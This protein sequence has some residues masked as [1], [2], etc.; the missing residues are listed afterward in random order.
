M[1]S[2][3]ISSGNLSNLSNTEIY[4][5]LFDSNSNPNDENSKLTKVQESKEL[6]PLTDIGIEMQEK[7][8]HEEFVFI[9]KNNRLTPLH[10]SCKLLRSP[11]AQSRITSSKIMS[12]IKALKESHKKEDDVKQPIIMRSINTY[13]LGDERSILNY[14]N[15]ENRLKIQRNIKGMVRN[16]TFETLE[17]TRKTEL[18]KRINS[19][20]PIDFKA[21]FKKKKYHDAKVKKW[22]VYESLE[23]IAGYSRDIYARGFGETSNMS[24]ISL[25]WDGNYNGSSWVPTESSMGNGRKSNYSLFQSNIVAGNVLQSNVIYDKVNTD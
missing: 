5:G 3:R 7:L 25:K 23:N 2:P 11:T 13:D 17:T 15:N 18:L 10:D 22:K 8:P 19:L 14:K 21:S 4:K 16:S 1:L 12:P 20:K 6:F 24:N 9:K